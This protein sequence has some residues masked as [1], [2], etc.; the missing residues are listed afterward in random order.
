MPINIRPFSETTH[1]HVPS[2]PSADS[3]ATDFINTLR[4][5][6]DNQD[7]AQR[8]KWDK[9]VKPP[10]KKKPVEPGNPSWMRV[11]KPAK[12]PPQPD[13]SSPKPVQKPKRQPWR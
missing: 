7:E 10:A 3:R 1:D 9:L 8:E 12:T 13:A 4:T 11:T 2:A 6:I 5:R